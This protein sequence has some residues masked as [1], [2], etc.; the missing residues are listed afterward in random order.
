[1]IAPRS[2]F[3]PPNTH[4]RVINVPIATGGRSYRSGTFL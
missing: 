2:R 1:M 3:H 4:R